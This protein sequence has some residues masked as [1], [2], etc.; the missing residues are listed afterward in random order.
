[1]AEAMAA[2]ASGA[3]GTWPTDNRGSGFMVSL[4]TDMS[5]QENAAS[6]MKVFS[7]A[8]NR[9]VVAYQDHDTWHPLSGSVA[10]ANGALKT[11][12]YNLPSAAEIEHP[13]EMRLLFS[14]L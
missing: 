7:G 6:Q 13:R 14:T 8:R 5:V 12:V 4:P 3:T 10:E 2:E 9:V 1:M 11:E